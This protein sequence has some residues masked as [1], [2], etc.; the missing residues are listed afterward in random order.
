MTP[1]INY[2]TDND[3][4]LKIIKDSI[5]DVKPNLKFF[6]GQNVMF[7]KNKKINKDEFDDSTLY[8]YENY[9]F[10]PFKIITKYKYRNENDSPWWSRIISDEFEYD[11]NLKILADK[12]YWIND[13]YF[14]LYQPNYAPR[15]IIREFSEFILKY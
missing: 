8:I 1:F 3:E 4:I 14:K 10:K 13:D 9:S 6:I 2:L 5:D 11:I 15:K 12:E 7:N